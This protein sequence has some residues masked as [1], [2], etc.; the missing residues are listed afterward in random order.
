MRSGSTESPGATSLFWMGDQLP[1]FDKYDG[2]HSA[3][4]GLLNGGYSGMGVGH[5]DIGGYTSLNDTE[6]LQF[7]QRDYEILMRWCE[8]SAFSDAIFRTHPSN[9]PDFNVQIWDNAEIAQFFKKFAQ[10]FVDLGSYKM[11]LMQEMEE[12]GIPIVR[13]LSLELNRTDIN[14]DDQFM[15]GSDYMVAPIF[16]QGS[17]SRKVYFPKGEW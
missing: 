6:G 3:M 16:K 10:V 9:N 8:M 4:I 14:I 2:L 11:N 13:S 1:T 17:N 7:Y 5:S 12:T 15:L